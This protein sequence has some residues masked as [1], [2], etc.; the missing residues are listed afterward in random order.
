MDA[1][2]MLKE[3]VRLT[4]DCAIECVDCRLH[5]TN[6]DMNFHCE[7]LLRENPETYVKIIEDWS[8]YCPK[9]T[10]LSKLLETFPGT[11]LTVEDNIPPFCPE[12]LGLKN[13]EKCQDCNADNELCIECWNQEYKE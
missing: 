5:R 11:R 2:Q 3:K 4:E 9:K 12:E 8:K 1:V 10:Y 13:I 7:D 6:N